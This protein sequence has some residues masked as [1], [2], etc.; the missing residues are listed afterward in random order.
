[1]PSGDIVSRLQGE[2]KDALKQGDK[3]RTDVLRLVL[4]AVKQRQIDSGE[5]VDDAGLIAVVE[6]MIKQRRES[7][8]HYEKAGRSDLQAQE[9]AEIDLLQP[10]MPNM[11]S[12][13]E[14]TAAIEEVVLK[15][16]V[17]SMRDM[18]KVMGVL[19]PRLTGRADMGMV[20][21][22]VKEKLS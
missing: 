11:M 8:S 7:I 16:E 1:M 22:I 20:S 18:G 19:K 3:P 17:T 13:A 2:I 5:E 12:E 10:F 4:A 6:K 9:Q 14:V 21:R 15:M